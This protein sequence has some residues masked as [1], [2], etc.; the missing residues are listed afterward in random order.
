LSISAKIILDAVIFNQG[1]ITSD[2]PISIP[3]AS[4]P[5]YDGPLLPNTK[6]TAILL[7]TVDTGNITLHKV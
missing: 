6:P 7:L 3:S 2:Y 5:S 1:K 4:P